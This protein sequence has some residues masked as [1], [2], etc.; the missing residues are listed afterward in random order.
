MKTAFT[1]FAIFLCALSFGQSKTETEI[2]SLS[3]EKFRWMLDKKLDSL[4]DI[5]D[6]KVI[7]QHASGM[8]QSKSEYLETIRSGKLIYNK[9]DI[10]ESSVR[11]IGQT[12]IVTGKV[13]FNVTING[14]IQDFNFTFTE[15]Y[16]KEKRDW[17]MV[18]DS[19][20][21]NN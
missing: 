6:E 15:V 13:D 10:K 5:L 8:V 2:L 16:S 12:A 3:K 4:S 1:F 7:M 18:L 19:F 14:S 21:K 17:K 20:R 11:I 9:I